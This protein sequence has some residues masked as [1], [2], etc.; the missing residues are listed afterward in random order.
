MTVKQADDSRGP[1]E[2]RRLWW[3]KLADAIADGICA[4]L[5]ILR[6][7]LRGWTWWI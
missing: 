5:N 1:D 7:L 4:V 3:Q 6:H 2:D